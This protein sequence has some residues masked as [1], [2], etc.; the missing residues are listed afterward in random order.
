MSEDDIP[1]RSYSPVIVNYLLQWEQLIIR[2]HLHDFL[3]K[4]L[5]GQKGV[6]DSHNTILSNWKRVDV[7]NHAMIR[8]P[9]LALAGSVSERA[10]W[11]GEGA[12]ES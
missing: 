12:S 1:F 3:M 5:Q 10:A 2:F 6:A 7:E 4:L 11:K 9:P 8:V